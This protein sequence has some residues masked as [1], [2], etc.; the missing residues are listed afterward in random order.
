MFEEPLHFGRCG[1][2]LSSRHRSRIFCTAVASRPPRRDQERQL[3]REPI[4]PTATLQ[5]HHGC[6][7]MASFVIPEVLFRSREVL[8]YAFIVFNAKATPVRYSTPR[9]SVPA[10]SPSTCFSLWNIWVLR[11]KWSRDARRSAVRRCP[12]QTCGCVTVLALDRCPRQQTTMI[13]GTDATEPT[14]NVMAEST[15]GPHAIYMMCATTWCTSAPT[16]TKNLRDACCF[17]Q[18]QERLTSKK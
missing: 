16:Q 11:G 13:L 14:A 2:F 5:R 6:I 10:P 18:L 1:A 8:F 3:G 9:R 17:A 12:S 7:S 15:L 4:S